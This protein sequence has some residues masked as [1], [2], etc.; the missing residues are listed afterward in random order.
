M[1]RSHTCA[2]HVMQAIRIYLQSPADSHSSSLRSDLLRELDTRFV[3]HTYSTLRPAYGVPRDCWNCS[4]LKGSDHGWEDSRLL[5]AV[6]L[7]LSGK[8]FLHEGRLILDVYEMA[9]P[10]RLVTR[11]H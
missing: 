4:F 3:I 7:T 5:L 11:H 8:Y 6:P 1:D 9:D 10:R 2:F